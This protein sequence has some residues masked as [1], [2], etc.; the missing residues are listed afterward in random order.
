MSSVITSED[1]LVETPGLDLLGELGWARADLMDEELGSNNPT[2]RLSFRELVLPA[3]LHD[4]LRKLNPLLPDEALRQAE[5]EL[6][7]NRS[8]M[9]PIVANREVYRL[10]RDGVVVQ[11]KQPDGSL[12][13][14]RAFFIDWVNPVA[15]DYLMASQVWIESRSI[16][17]DPM[18]SAL[19]TAFPCC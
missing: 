17:A 11:V 6:T 13:D 9:L 3:R 10:L 19:S 7:T 8:A 12:Q 4:A 1:E 14:E 2:G 5:T 16:H 15:N 18:P